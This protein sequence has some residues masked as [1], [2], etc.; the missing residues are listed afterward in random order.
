[1]GIETLSLILMVV[2]FGIL[3]LGLWVGFALIAVGLVAMTLASSAPAELVFGTKVWGALNIWDL[4]A[5]PR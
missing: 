5:L 4:T 1:M 2:L 3:A